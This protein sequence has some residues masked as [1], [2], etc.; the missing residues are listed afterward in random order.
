MACCLCPV[1]CV[2]G[3]GVRERDTTQHIEESRAASLSPDSSLHTPVGKREGRAQPSQPRL[4]KT[5]V[6]SL[7]RRSRS[8]RD[9]A[10]PESLVLYPERFNHAD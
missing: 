7:E 4:A 2:P 3:S 1:S 6:A 10:H 5:L 9:F 8:T